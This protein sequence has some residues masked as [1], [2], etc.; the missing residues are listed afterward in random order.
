MI[1]NNHT[2]DFENANVCY[3]AAQFS[4]V[5]PISCS[6][7]TNVYGTRRLNREATHVAYTGMSVIRV[8]HKFTYCIL[9]YWSLEKP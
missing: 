4:L 9:E 2:L 8:G 1:V 7:L 3:M 6:S 5:S